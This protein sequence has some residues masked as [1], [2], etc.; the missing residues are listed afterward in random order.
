MATPEKIF[1]SQFTEKTTPTTWDVFPIA[2][3]ADWDKL[4]WVNYSVIET[5]Q[6]ASTNHIANT[7]NPHS[8]TKA[9]VWLWSVV[10]ADTTT[11]ANI[12]DSTNK[13]FMSDAQETN[14][15]NQS[16][17]NTWDETTA[18][19]KTKLWAA[20]TSTD[21]YLTSTDRNTFN[22]KQAALWYTAENTANK[23]TSLTDNSDTYYPSQKAVKTAVD[24]KVTW[25]ATATDNA[26]PV[27][28]W[29]TGKLV[30]DSIIIHT[31]STQ[32]I[33]LTNYS[34][35]YDSTATSLVFNVF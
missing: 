23:K 31:A 26:I 35:E 24:A 17:T 6:T 16:N 5:G 33:G 3:N 29:V 18:T 8:V 19:I 28:D 10:N 32:K 22:D 1:P 21:G 27:Y 4:K 11:T 13:R 12:T 14:L 15:N 7:S 20:T 9:Q 25:P 30:K 34:M 2:D